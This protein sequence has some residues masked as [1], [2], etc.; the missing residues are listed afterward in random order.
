MAIDY[1]IDLDCE[2]KRALTTDDILERIKGAERAEAIIKLFR[3]GGDA[4]PPAEMSFEFTRSTPQGEETR[5]FSVQD[6]L[7]RAEALKAFEHHCTHCPANNRRRPFGCIG[8]I[9]YPITK[10]AEN[11]LLDRLPTPDDAL[12]LLLLNQGVQDFKYDGATVK[13]LRQMPGV[14]F[15][16]QMPEARR[17]GDSWLDADQLFEMIF[18]VGNINPNHAALLLLFLHAIRRDIEAGEIMS[19]TREGQR[20]ALKYP[21]TL[22]ERD[23]DEPTIRELIVFL[24]A[25]HTGWKLR[26]RVLI[27]A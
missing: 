1:I 15:E 18:A 17:L 23:H 14:Y 7:D 25:L 11:W 26:V 13:P 3:D 22:D 21:F 5:E 12:I 8:F 9:E 24:R 6:L 10:H 2:P 4:R 27:D 16:D 20:A 19:I